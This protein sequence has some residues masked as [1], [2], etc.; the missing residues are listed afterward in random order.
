[1]I[2]FALQ[3]SKSNLNSVSINGDL[4][5]DYKKQNA[6][7]ALNANRI[8]IKKTYKVLRTCTYMDAFWLLLCQKEVQ[9]NLQCMTFLNPE[10]TEN[11]EK[12]YFE[13]NHGLIP[14]PYTSNDAENFP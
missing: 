13:V 2:D 4:W 6:E 1:M 14:H 10:M 9:K 12:V 3:G 8:H 7:N 11:D 5:S